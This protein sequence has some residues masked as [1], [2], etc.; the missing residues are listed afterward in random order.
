MRL[1]ALIDLAESV[2]QKADA[3]EVKREQ[4]REEYARAKSQ[5][6]ARQR[7]LDEAREAQDDWNARWE[8]LLGQCWLGAE[9]M[10]RRPGEVRDVLR[11]LEDLRSAVERGETLERNMERWRKTE[12]TPTGAGRSDLHILGPTYRLKGV[13][14]AIP[15]TSFR[16]TGEGWYPWNETNRQLSYW[17]TLER[18]SKWTTLDFAPT[19]A[20]SSGVTGWRMETFDKLRTLSETNPHDPNSDEFDEDNTSFWTR[21]QFILRRSRLTQTPVSG[22]PLSGGGILG[23]GYY[24]DGA[25]ALVGGTA[26]VMTERRWVANDEGTLWLR[27]SQTLERYSEWTQLDMMP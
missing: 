5:H 3:R 9:G 4:K 8:G 1:D 12:T 13:T 18:Y 19:T 17:Q 2:A 14:Q 22:S 21:T 23:P 20:A 10:E 25:T 26:F 16:I 11:L 7:R 15:G 24:F 6:E 27:E